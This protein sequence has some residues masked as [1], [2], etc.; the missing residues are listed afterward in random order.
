[1]KK[2]QV[3]Y[4]L[5]EY[6]SMSS[7]STQELEDEWGS[8]WTSI[9][10]AER[11]WYLVWRCEVTHPTMRPNGFKQ[12]LGCG[13][14]NV[15]MT[16]NDPSGAIGTAGEIQAQCK[17]KRKKRLSRNNVNLYEFD[18][19]YDAEYRATLLNNYLEENE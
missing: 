5:N 1:M 3:K 12:T 18:N 19:R 7:D 2:G 13:H 17:C 8:G 15:R 10:T 6:K 16:K 9:G 14:W 11:R 4:V